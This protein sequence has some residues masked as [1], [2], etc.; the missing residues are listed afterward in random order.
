MSVL[1]EACVSQVKRLQRLSKTCEL[2]ANHS[3]TALLKVRKN[4]MYIDI[5][6]SESFCAVECRIPERTFQY[7]R[8][9]VD[10]GWQAKIH[11]DQLAFELKKLARSKQT[12]VFLSTDD[13]PLILK[14]KT[15]DAV[16]PIASTEHRLRKF[17][18]LQV[19]KFFD[20]HD[21]LHIRLSNAELNRIVNHQCVASGLHGGVASIRVLTD[22]LVVTFALMGDCGAAVE[23]DIHPAA[24][25]VV[26]APKTAL[27]CTYFLT[28]WKRAQTMFAIHHE[29]THVY[30][31][32]HG[33]FLVQEFIDQPSV[34]VCVADVSNVDLKSYV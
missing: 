9:A 5:T 24:S 15:R 11:M 31:A 12:V 22:P 20:G 21:Y 2:L 16:I 8:L 17:Y 7:V 29:F 10:Q 33:V 23:F 30:V 19:S 13:E 3:D 25:D 32:N 27:R 28:Y 34:F 14:L 18:P 6:D 1:F 26:H 4:G